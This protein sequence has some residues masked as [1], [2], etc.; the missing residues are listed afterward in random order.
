[1]ND[2]VCRKDALLSQTEYNKWLMVHNFS[3]ILVQLRLI[4]IFFFPKLLHQILG[5]FY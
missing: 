4:S 1:M 5:H 3:H 2:E